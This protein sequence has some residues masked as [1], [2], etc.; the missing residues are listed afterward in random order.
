MWSCLHI[1]S[2]LHVL[3]F[4][5]NA[6]AS[7]YVSTFTTKPVQPVMHMNNRSLKGELQVSFMMELNACMC[8]RSSCVHACMMYA[9]S[10]FSCIHVCEAS[11]HACML[12]ALC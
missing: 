2:A 6:C 12:R 10:R 1:L 8:A 5:L 7:V 9:S 11:F 4:V 3:T